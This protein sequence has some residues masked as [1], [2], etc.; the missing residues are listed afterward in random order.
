[1]RVAALLELIAEHRPF[2]RRLGIELVRPAHAA[3]LGS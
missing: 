3:D 2:R 1:V